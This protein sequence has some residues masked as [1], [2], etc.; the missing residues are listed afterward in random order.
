MGG[1]ELLVER[2]FFLLHPA[3][4]TTA[5]RSTKQVSARFL[6]VNLFSFDKI[7][8]PNC[9]VAE[10]LRRGHLISNSSLA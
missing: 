6:E 4:P 1:A 8:T 3:K 5:T 7:K 2:G 10:I 9:I